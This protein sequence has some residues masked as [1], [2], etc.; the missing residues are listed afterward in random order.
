MNHTLEQLADKLEAIANTGVV[1]WDKFDDDMLR[2]A[3]AALRGGG[4]G[5]S[6][7]GIPYADEGWAITTGCSPCSSGCTHCYAARLAAT[8]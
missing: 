6:N 1:S 4:G 5:M 8:R 7:T 2:A 3:S